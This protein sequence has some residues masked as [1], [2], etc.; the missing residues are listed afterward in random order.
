MSERYTD[1]NDCTECGVW[2]RPSDDVRATHD[3]FHDRIDLLHAAVLTQEGQDMAAEPEPKRHTRI[4]E[5]DIE[6]HARDMFG[7]PE[8]LSWVATFLRTREEPP[9]R[10]PVWWVD[11]WWRGER[12][13]YYHAVTKGDPYPGQQA[14]TW[15]YMVG[16]S[17]GTEPLVEDEP[18]PLCAVCGEPEP[19]HVPRMYDHTFTL[20]PPSE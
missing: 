5:A 13:G 18:E 6:Q 1:L 14:P 16:A 17:T 8:P 9:S 4:T 19:F 11:R 2:V 3:A 15:A 12:G 20:T 7:E 10:T